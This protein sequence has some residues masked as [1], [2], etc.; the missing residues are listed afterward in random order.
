MGFAPRDAKALKIREVLLDFLG[1]EVPGRL[2]CLDIGCGSGEIALRLADLFSHSIGLDR[3]LDQ[4]EDRRSRRPSLDLLQADGIR[5]PFASAS[6]NVVICAQVYEH[7]DHAER[8]PAEVERVLKPG[9]I[10]FFSGPNK[11][12]PVEPHYG[13]P[14]LHWLPGRLADGYLQATGRGDSFEIRPYTAWRLRRLWRR[15]VRHDYT[16]RMLRE[17]DRFGLSGSIPRFMQRVPVFVFRMV[18]DLLPN[19]NWILVK[20]DA[21]SI[22]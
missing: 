11:V 15:F 2:R 20:R 17:P 19:Y 7:V 9:G 22:H 10:C 21:Q 3:F 5:L 4:V 13:L 12:W 18:Y 14:F 6:F 1:P 16:I 8:L